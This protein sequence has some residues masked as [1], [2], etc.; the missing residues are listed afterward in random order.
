MEYCARL[1]SLV[2]GLVLIN[3]DRDAFEIA[4]CQASS[5]HSVPLREDRSSLVAMELYS[6]TSSCTKSLCDTENKSVLERKEIKV[7]ARSR[8]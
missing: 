7:M 6:V 1:E 2:H 4:R 8:P 3:H 5:L